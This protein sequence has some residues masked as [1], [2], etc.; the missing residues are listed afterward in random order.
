MEELLRLDHPDYELMVYCPSYN[1]TYKKAQTC[2]R[3]GQNDEA[4]YSIYKWDNNASLQINGEQLKQEKKYRS[5]FFENT[6]YQFWISFKN[7]EVE[8]AWINTPL[9]SIQDNFM[10]NQNNR[11]LFGHLNYGND[12]GKTEIN[13]DY[14][15]KNGK[16]KHSQ[17]CYDVL[18]IKLNY[19]KD[20]KKIINDIEKEY[21]CYISI[22]EEVH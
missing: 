9:K 8:D 20:L 18:S 19:H 1:K 6:D 16:I 21:G 7:K 3:V 4:L 5:I 2:M 22:N 10:F 17:L 11:V 14:K 12:I 15:L 13:I